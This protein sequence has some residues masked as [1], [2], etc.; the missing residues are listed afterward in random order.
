MKLTALIVTNVALALSC[1]AAEPNAAL[2][3]PDADGFISLFN[4]KDL[5]GW[6]GDTKFWSVK[7]G[8]IV[9]E[10]SPDNTTK[11]TYIFRSGV[12]LADFELRA[13]FK[14]LSGNSGI[15]YRSEQLP[16]WQTRGYQADM[17]AGNHYTGMLYDCAGRGIIMKRGQKLV[18]DAAGKKE[19]TG[20]L[21]DDKELLGAIKAADW[22]DMTIIARGHHLIHK[23]NGRAMADVID[24][25]EGKR[26]DSGI[27]GFQ[28]HPGPPMRVEFKDIRVKIL[29]P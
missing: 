12:V 20:T 8:A 13:K 21:G 28:L 22:N 6:D 14:L 2:P 24:E 29:K 23:I 4:G 9:G 7:D 5:A 15:Q 18:I 3:P 1:L 19:I 11:G 25:Q 17:D 10:T 16:N 26:R 27:I